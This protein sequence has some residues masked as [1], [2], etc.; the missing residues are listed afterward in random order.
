MASLDHGK[1]SLSLSFGEGSPLSWGK[2]RKE[3]LASAPPNPER[4]PQSV[5]GAV[6][7]GGGSRGSQDMHSLS[8][9]LRM[10]CVM[11]LLFVAA[12]LLALWLV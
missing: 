8:S 10:L 11:C 2:V 3:S 6:D 4:A 9:P 12:V 1:V 7:G 5:V